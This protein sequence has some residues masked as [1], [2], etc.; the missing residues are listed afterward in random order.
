MGGGEL[1]EPRHM[2]HR[3]MAPRLRGPKAEPRL[4]RRGA[5]M[6]GG[7]TLSEINRSIEKMS[8]EDS[9]SCGG[10]TAKPSVPPHTTTFLQNDSNT[11]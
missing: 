4:P 7:G 10:G 3:L 5:Q 9:F 8:L 2:H 1:V 6:L 11:R